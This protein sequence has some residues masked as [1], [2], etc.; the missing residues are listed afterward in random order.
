MSNDLE[1]F[2]EAFKGHT[3]A[4]RFCL[5][6]LYVVHLWDDLID[7]DKPRSDEDINK[8]F[9]AALLFIPANPF[10]MAHAHALQPMIANAISLW[11]EANKR[12]IMDR[13]NKLYAY[14]IRNAGLMPIYYA[15]QAV[16]GNM[17]ILHEHFKTQIYLNFIDFM[18]DRDNA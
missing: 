13:E 8:A 16:G 15:C 18:G 11:Y 9:E 6:L 3:D 12:E 7:K 5:D 10:Y 17:T 14:L 2:Q 1:I 4:I